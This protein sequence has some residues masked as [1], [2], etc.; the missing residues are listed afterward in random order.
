MR[1]RFNRMGTMLFLAASVLST[2]GI[3][4]CSDD[5]DLPDTKPSFLGAS[6]YDE[7][8]KRDTFQT[9]V[10]LIDDLG[11]SDV[12]SST[13][14]NT[15]FVAS[16]NAFKRFFD[17][18]VFKD[19]QGNPVTSYEQLSI[20]QKRW[21]L[22]G[23]M[24]KN[25]YVLEML[26]NTSGG[27]AGKNLCLRQSS[28]LSVLDSIPYWNYYDLPVNQYTPE[29]G[30][31]AGSANLN[32]KDFWGYYNTQQR[33]GMWMAVDGTDPM[34]THFLQ[35]QLNDKSITHGDIEFIL[36]QPEGSW[37]EN[38]EDRSYIYDRQIIEQDVT[39][40]NGY[41]HVL[42]NVLVT[43][44]N[45]AEVIRTNGQTNLFSKMLDRF[46]LPYYDAN[47]TENYNR[48][49]GSV[50]GGDSIFKKMYISNNN[51][52]GTS[53]TTDRR[54]V[55][56]GNE[57]PLLPFD[58]G[59][60]EYAM[61]SSVTK[62]NDMAAMFV[63]SD[64]ALAKYFLPGGS[65]E[66]LMQRYAKLPNT[67]ENLEY[68]LAQVPI[69]VLKS[70]V[71]NLMKD[72]FNES[73]PSKYNLIMNDAQDY[74]FDPNDYPTLASYKALFDK[75]LM[76][77]NGVVYVMNTVI[78]PADYAAVS[79]PALLSPKTKVFSS[80]IQ[81]DDNYIQG[82][83]YNNAPLKQYFST[84]LKA[85]QS[86]FTLFAPTDEALR[87]YGYVDPVG[88]AS[89]V[90]NRRRYWSWEYSA[91]T[92]TSTGI[93]LLPI[94]ATPYTY[95]INTARDAD[96]DR[97]N[98]AASVSEGREN[99][100]LGFGPTKRELAIEMVNQHILIHDD[101]ETEGIMADH[102]FFTSRSGAPIKVLS[103]GNVND[104]NVGMQVVG[105]LQ[106]ALNEDNIEANDEVCNV[107]EG[108]NKFVGY[109]NGFTYFLDRAMQPTMKTTYSA[110]STNPNF[111]KFFSLLD[112]AKV[113]IDLLEKAGFKDS[114]PESDDG[115]LWKAEQRKYQVFTQEKVNVSSNEYLVRF[116]NNYRY[117]IYIPTNDAVDRALAQGLPTWETI[118][119]FYENNKDE[120][121]LL[122]DENKAKMQAMIVC[123]VNFVK[124]H[125]QDEAIYV[126]RVKGT[127]N[128]TYQSACTVH[129]AKENLDNI[130]YLNVT[131]SNNKIMVKDEGQKTVNVIAPYNNFTREM[132][133][134]ADPTGS[135]AR[136]VKNSSYVTVHQIDD[137]L[138]FID[139]AKEGRFDQAWKSEGAARK[140]VVKYRLR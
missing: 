22:F 49:Y 93:P 10:R 120:D 50:T 62:E 59:W 136:N 103:R 113:D 115:T 26:S 139:P 54:G 138:S 11:Y 111:S 9:T 99:L 134:N 133:F 12:L 53:I 33:G 35:G 41:F 65:G 28:S 2:G 135:A 87:K 89:G 140:F 107:T 75:T 24:L 118:H 109:G 119:D 125:F 129:D 72:S 78:A 76:A 122:S 61:S 97:R 6:I 132:N 108:Y 55:T 112:P 40:L 57:F 19:G 58:P 116:F 42:D 94:K 34:I 38:A 81:A 17:Q 1:N 66:D 131:R 32:A 128:G 47:L 18:G 46:S 110:L 15:L 124:Y 71:N 82:N 79:A 14:S 27:A 64:E 21:L 36:N 117:T 4:S 74:M 126:D 73:V 101:S 52:T 51:A 121:E 98:T 92:S 102:D 123:L 86:H 80:I 39:C 69:T 105:G 106:M 8:V 43:P 91:N 16:D 96:V 23:S 5:Y 104:N 31:A 90:A 37:P 68:N 44:P 67:R 100:S 70:L 3:V 95:N 84:Y 137:Y 130:L 60:N 56:I 114:I 45:M 85:M 29:E 77:S 25:A 88:E 13:G 127:E 20:S 30:E 63:P 83:S 7:L 48:I